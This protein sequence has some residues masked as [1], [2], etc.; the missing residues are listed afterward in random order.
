[1]LIRCSHDWAVCCRSLHSSSEFEFVLCVVVT[2]F[3]ESSI[4]T[5][6]CVSHLLL[7]FGFVE[8]H[9]GDVSSIDLMI[10]TLMKVNS[11]PTDPLPCPAPWIRYCLWKYDSLE[12][13]SDVLMWK[14]VE[15]R[16]LA[17]S[18]Q[19]LFGV[20]SL[21]LLIYVWFAMILS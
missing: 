3:R 2:N 14:L 11:L 15:W 18:L 1:M 16:V 12:V 19:T 8:C 20:P 5:D 17:R 6:M 21:R 10:G 4:N 13:P 9:M 7:L